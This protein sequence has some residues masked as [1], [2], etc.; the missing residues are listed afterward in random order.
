MLLDTHLFQFCNDGLVACCRLTNGDTGSGSQR[1]VDV[2]ARAKFD[3]AEVLV[4]ITLLVG[5]GIGDDTAGHRT[6][7]LSY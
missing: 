1:Q 5:L 4:N 3:K 2:H 7:N 6:G